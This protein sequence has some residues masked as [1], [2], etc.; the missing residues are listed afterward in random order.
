MS[1]FVLALGCAFVTACSDAV[2]KRIMWDNDEWLAG[3]VML[4]I[5]ALVLTPVFLSQDLMPVSQDLVLLIIIALP[6][7]ICAYYL[8]LSALRMAPISLTL[9]LLAFTPVL[10]ILT[11]SVLLGESISLRG[12]AGI[13]LVTIGAYIL[14][15]DLLNRSLIAPI[16]A[17]FVEPGCRR[18]L[19]VAFA[20]SVTSALGKKGILL[21]G[22]IP[23]G[24]VLVICAAIAFAVISLLRFRMGLSR[25]DLNRNSVPLF[26]L[27]GLLMAGAQLTHFLS[28]SLAPVA[29]MISVKR[30]SLVFGVIL[31][32][33]LFHE[34]NL[35]Y[36][37][38]GASVMAIGVFLIYE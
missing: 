1:W 16:Q 11:S 25:Q 21:Y 34:G 14:N 13:G 37:L 23:F 8:F 36:R 27:G 19:L 9:P 33:L 18:M 29:Y 10:T 28:L 6:L 5:A 22:A 26:L 32:R 15:G 20:W 35:G 17:V 4:S 3:A 24:A 31:G 30:L 2:S 12:A 38:T 7:E